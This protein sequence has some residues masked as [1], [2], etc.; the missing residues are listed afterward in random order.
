[1]G[2]EMCIRDRSWTS[3]SGTGIDSVYIYKGTSSSYQ[4]L[5][6]VIV[7]TDTSHTVTGLTNNTTYY[8]SIKYK[9]ADGSFGSVSEIVS[10]TPNYNG[11]VWYMSTNAVIVMTA[12]LTPRF[13]H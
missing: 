3:P 9:G 10:A 4:T 11:P 13:L 8:F 5:S 12:V 2:S 1:M 7:V 6:T